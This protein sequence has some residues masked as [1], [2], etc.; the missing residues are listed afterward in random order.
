MNL[1]NNEIWIK[2]SKINKKKAKIDT[3]R[4]NA[5]PE[6]IINST[7]FEFKSGSTKHGMVDPVQFYSK[8]IDR[9]KSKTPWSG[10]PQRW[11]E[12]YWVDDQNKIW[13][14]DFSNS[15]HKFEYHKGIYKTPDSPSKYKKT[16]LL[17]N[18]LFHN[19]SS[20]HEQGNLF[21]YL[22]Y[23]ANFDFESNQ[24]LDKNLVSQRKSS[25]NKNFEFEMNHRLLKI[26][27]KPRKSGN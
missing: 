4:N 9:Y 16:C 27:E 8:I 1:Q 2:G 6:E 7:P 17:S 11:S 3:G 13:E 18:I 21:V 5:S 14:K 15:K 22:P 10:T 24:Q 19:K 23:L 26:L 20:K 25:Y 12:R